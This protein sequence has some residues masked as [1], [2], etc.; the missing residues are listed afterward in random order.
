ME[1][2]V[3]CNEEGGELHMNSI[4]VEELVENQE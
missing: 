3:R 1:I 4:E 2:G